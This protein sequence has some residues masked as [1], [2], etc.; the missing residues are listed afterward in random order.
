MN[1]VKSITYKKL[2]RKSALGLAHVDT[3]EIEIDSRLEGFQLL[4][5]IVH[6][7]MHVQNPRW[8]ELQVEGHSKEMANILWKEGFRK[9]DLGK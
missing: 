4:Y 3:G 1:T 9:V 7:T 2:G 6:E 5:V 8:S